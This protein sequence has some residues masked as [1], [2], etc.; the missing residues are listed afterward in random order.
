MLGNP[1]FFCWEGNNEVEAK[2]T[3]LDMALKGPESRVFLW[4]FPKIVGVPS[5]SSILIR[6]SIINHPF[7]GTPILGN[8]PYRTSSS[9]SLMESNIHR[10][11]TLKVE[12]C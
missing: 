7:W 2:G 1:V 10:L 4:M 11:C 12:L 8:I 5:K 3:W 6:F 9:Y